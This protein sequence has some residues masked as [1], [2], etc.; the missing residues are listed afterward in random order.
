MRLTIGYLWPT[1]QVR[2][3]SVTTENAFLSLGQTKG[4][5]R[6]PSISRLIGSP[7]YRNDFV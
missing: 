2:L 3:L 5:G 7:V 1:G 4:I 6:K